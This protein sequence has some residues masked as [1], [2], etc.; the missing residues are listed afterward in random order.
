MPVTTEGPCERDGTQRAPAPEAG[1][2]SASGPAPRSTPTG[3]VE[4]HQ[5]DL[6]TRRSPGAM[7]S[8]RKPSSKKSSVRSSGPTA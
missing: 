3:P 1:T 7:T 6:T 5:F 4:P 8:T 2:R